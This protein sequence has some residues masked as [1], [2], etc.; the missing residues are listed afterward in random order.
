VLFRHRNRR[1]LFLLD[2]ET[3][4]YQELLSLLPDEIRAP[5]VSPD[6]RWIYFTRVEGEADVWMLTLDEEQK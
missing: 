4:R 6:N 3:G 5:S 2:I 1:T